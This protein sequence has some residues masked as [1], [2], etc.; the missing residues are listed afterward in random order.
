LLP[1]L[2]LALFVARVGAD[3]AHHAFTA[4]DAAVL[5]NA[6]NGT[7][8]FH[9]FIFYSFEWSNEGKLYQKSPL[10]RKRVF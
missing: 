6:T 9:N 7:T 5:A 1:F 8:Y 3:H 4:D 2:S 10:P